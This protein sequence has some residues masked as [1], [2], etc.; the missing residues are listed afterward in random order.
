MPVIDEGNE[1]QGHPQMAR[2]LSTMR[3]RQYIGAS[4]CGITA[5]APYIGA[6]RT[7]C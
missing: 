3:L 4:R 6:L 5:G 7:K 2:A 1:C